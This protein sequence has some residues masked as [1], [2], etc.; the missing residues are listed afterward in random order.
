MGKIAVLQF[1]IL[2]VILILCTVIVLRDGEGMSN[3]RHATLHYTDWCPHCQT[4]KPVW[5]QV[6]HSVGPNIMFHEVDEEKT[7]TP[8]I[9]GYPTIIMIDETGHA[10]QYRDG[11]NVESLRKWL[12][13]TKA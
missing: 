4:M 5:N 11:P 8:G 3:I 6:K 13:N 2:I 12:I 9:T 1:T 10:H 7:P